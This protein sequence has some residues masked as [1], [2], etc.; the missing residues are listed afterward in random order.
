ML[1]FHDVRDVVQGITWVNSSRN[2]QDTLTKP[3]KGKKYLEI[4]QHNKFFV[5]DVFSPDNNIDS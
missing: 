1:R 4:Y 5:D 2:K 3:M